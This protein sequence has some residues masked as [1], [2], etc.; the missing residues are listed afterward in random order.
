MVEN[1]NEAILVSS[2]RNT[3]RDQ[4]RTLDVLWEFISEKDITAIM[5]KLKERNL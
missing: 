3:V 2:L 1:I 4:Q 5:Q